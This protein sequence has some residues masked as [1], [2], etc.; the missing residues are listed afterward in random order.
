MVIFDNTE[1]RKSFS[2]AIA[3]WNY[4]DWEIEREREEETKKEWGRERII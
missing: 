2:V 4:P 3:Q 1:I